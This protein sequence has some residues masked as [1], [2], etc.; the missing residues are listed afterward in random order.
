MKTTSIQ[1]K[2]AGFFLAVL[3][4][5]AVLGGTVGGM[6]ASAQNVSGQV[7]T[8]ERLVVS[9]ETSTAVN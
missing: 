8:L 2:I 5:V 9:A 1:T 6:E 3:A 4:S 7:V